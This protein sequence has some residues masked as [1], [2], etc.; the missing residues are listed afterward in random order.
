MKS[1]LSLF[2]ALAAQAA[3]FAEPARPTPT[4]KPDAKPAAKSDSKK[5]PD[6][7]DNEDERIK[8]VLEGVPADQVFHNVQIP[9]LGPNGK[10]Q[11]LFKA[12]SAKRIGDRDMEMQ[13]L[14]I[15]IHN[16]DGT[17]FHVEMAHSIFN[18][19]T[20]ILTSDT[21]T[22]IKR[23]DFVIN[24]DRAEFHVKSRFGRVMGNVKMTIFNTGGDTVP[25]RKK[26]KPAKPTPTPEPASK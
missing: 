18:F 4:P 26:N 23:D 2:L 11:S 3:L 16:D 22:T 6:P 21:P 14:Q 10:T 9:S 13:G 1:W 17:T 25:K 12:E 20:K 7:S 8:K 15:E 19:D 5:N 24:G